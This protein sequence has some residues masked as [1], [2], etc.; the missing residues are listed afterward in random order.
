MAYILTVIA[1]LLCVFVSFVV[2]KSI[3]DTVK[4]NSKFNYWI[5]IVYLTSQFSVYLFNVLHKLIEFTFN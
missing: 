2:S 4:S 1:I 5:V 3:I